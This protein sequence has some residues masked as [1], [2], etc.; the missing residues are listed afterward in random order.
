[1]CVQCLPLGTTKG[2]LEVE[3]GDIKGTV[4]G[5]KEYLDASR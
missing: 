5:D 1:M 3:F 2:S 4:G